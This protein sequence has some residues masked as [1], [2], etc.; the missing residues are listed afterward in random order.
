[1]L[2]SICL[3]QG[4]HF[5]RVQFMGFKKQHTSPE[6]MLFRKCNDGLVELESFKRKQ[7]VVVPYTIRLFVNSKCLFAA[8]DSL[9]VFVRNSVAVGNISPRFN[10]VV[11][12]S[13]N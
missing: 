6:Q 12:N 2:K 11:I 9:E 3:Q 10:L 13:D 7:N 5:P 1:M 8:G 4:C